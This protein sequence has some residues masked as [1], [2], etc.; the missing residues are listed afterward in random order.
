MERQHLIVQLKK[1]MQ[2]SKSKYRNHADIY[3]TLG[4]QFIFS[5]KKQE[6]LTNRV[7]CLHKK[8]DVRLD[9]T[10]QQSEEQFFII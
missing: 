2:S 10:T 3:E 1:E 7:R 6:R 8:Q 9:V 5:L 4:K